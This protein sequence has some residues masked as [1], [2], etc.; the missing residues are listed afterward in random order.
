MAHIYHSS[1]VEIE[2]KHAIIRPIDEEDYHVAFT[3]QG[4]EEDQV[5]EVL[6]SAGE[7][8]TA[9]DLLFNR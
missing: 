8:K 6:F 1:K 2:D 5:T 3:F 9:Y 4:D 7:I